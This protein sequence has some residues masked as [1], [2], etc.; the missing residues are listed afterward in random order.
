[1]KSL[2]HAG[3]SS[4]CDVFLDIAN[5]KIFGVKHLLSSAGMTTSSGGAGTLLETAFGILP[6]NLKA[7][8]YYPLKMEL[9]TA[10]TKRPSPLTLGHLQPLKSGDSVSKLIA[11]YGW[12]YINTKGTLTRRISLTLRAGRWHDRGFTLLYDEDTEKLNI[13][14]DPTKVKSNKKDRTKTFNTLGDW[15]AQVRDEPVTLEYDLNEVVKMLQK[16]LNRLA[17]FYYDKTGDFIEF[18]KADIYTGVCTAKIKEMILS[19]EV[20]FEIAASLI[21]DHGVA[22]RMR[23]KDT[24]LFYP[25]ENGRTSLAPQKK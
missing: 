11:T 14:Y 23:L 9:K 12:N 7:A 1:M 20:C 13:V 22:L 24:P 5:T 21:H 15:S 18:K 17:I 8:D 4:A 3:E 25:N 2:F 19:G 10:K 16:K 6:N